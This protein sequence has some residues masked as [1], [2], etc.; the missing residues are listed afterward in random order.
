[1]IGWFDGGAGA[2][3][4]MML[5]ALVGATLTQIE[6]PKPRLVCVMGGGGLR[7]VLLEN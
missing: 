1:M 5:G 7:Y 6:T 2:S 3:G 4:D